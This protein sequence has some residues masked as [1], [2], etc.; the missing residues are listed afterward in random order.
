MALDIEKLAAK[1]AE[2]SAKAQTIKTPE[3]AMAFAFQSLDAIRDAKESLVTEAA[4]IDVKEAASFLIPLLPARYQ[5]WAK[6]ALIAM[7]FLGIGSGGTVAIDKPDSIVVAAPEKTP[8]QIAAEKEAAE[9]QAAFRQSISDML[10]KL[11]TTNKSVDELKAEASKKKV[12]KVYD[13]EG[14][15]MSERPYNE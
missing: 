9:K 6:Y 14:R 7:T 3:E 11:E 12:L 10:A 15:L 5:V 1:A 4:K 13:T 2:L 8:E